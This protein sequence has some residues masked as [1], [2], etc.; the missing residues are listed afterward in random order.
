MYLPKIEATYLYLDTM[1]ISG[2]R[3]NTVCIRK[4]ERLDGFPRF[5]H[6]VWRLALSAERFKRTK[7]KR[8]E[9]Y[10]HFLR[11]CI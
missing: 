4:P 2:E 3:E 10:N 11:P 6:E 1:P 7:S 5:E 8:T 9:I